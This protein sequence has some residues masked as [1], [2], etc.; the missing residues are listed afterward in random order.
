MKTPLDQAQDAV[1]V[2]A[3]A[4][5][6]A[7]GKSTAP[8]LAR[9]FFGAWARLMK[10]YH[11]LPSGTD[12]PVGLPPDLAAMLHGLFGYLGVGHIPD[13]ILDAAKGAGRRSIGPV[14]RRDI[15]TAVAYV[16]AAK[17]G[18]IDDKS[19]VQTICVQYEVGRSTVQ[20]WLRSF[21]ERS[22][23]TQLLP[24]R[25]KESAHRYRI[26]GRSHSAIQTRG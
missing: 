17:R 15:E 18:E 22:I 16:R 25:M 23:Q 1:R 2:A 14:E 20:G 10:F 7:E 4:L 9:E 26:A 3:S 19:P 11:P 6:A 21:D 24:R 8:R 5:A 12:D 13:P